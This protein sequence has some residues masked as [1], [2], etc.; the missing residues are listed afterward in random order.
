MSIVN[1]IKGLVKR[2]VRDA[3][4]W[5]MSDPTA[6]AIKTKL[7]IPARFHSPARSVLE[8]TILPYYMEKN[9]KLRLLFVGSDWYTKHY[10]KWFRHYQEYWTIDPD[11][12]QKSYGAKHHIVDVLE[13]L[14]QYFKPEHFDVIICNGVL[15]HGINDREAVE[16]AFGACF[17]CMTLGGTFVL[18]WG[19]SP[20]LLTFPL[21][22]SE[23]LR[24]FTPFEFPPFKAT[25]H[26]TVPKYQ[27]VFNFYQKSPRRSDG[28]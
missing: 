10:E 6:I 20:D 16:K 3:E 9:A 13:N 18:G 17:E 26:T 22:E 25:S 4:T 21:E 11:P 5:W 19:G 8:E 27:Y 12:N 7:G 2:H 28:H 1:R 23:S 24:Q 15:G 14:R